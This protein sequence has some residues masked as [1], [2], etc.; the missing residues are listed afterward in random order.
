MAPVPHDDTPPPRTPAFAW[1]SHF[2]SE[3]KILLGIVGAISIFFLMLATGLYARYQ[4]SL[5]EN[6]DKFGTL[7][8]T[9]VAAE[10]ADRMQSPVSRELRIRTFVDT[11]L[12]SSNDL[13]AIEFQDASG[14]VLYENHKPLPTADLRSAR[15]YM[16]KIQDLNAS[17]PSAYLGSA[18][19]KLT[20]QSIHEISNY[21]RTILLVVF[22]CAWLL[23]LLAVSTNTYILHQ[24]L[25]RLVQGVKRLSTGDFGYKISESDLWGELRTLAESFNDMSLRLR[26]YEDQNLDVIT[27]ERNKLQ[28][29]LMSIADGIIVCNNDDEVMI[30]NNSACRHLSI[31]SAAMLT[32]RNIRDYVSVKGEHCL[33]PL[34]EEFMELLHAQQGRMSQPLAKQLTLPAITLNVMISPIQDADGA[35]LGFVIITHDITREAEVDRMKTNF[36]SNVSH[37][38]R[39][40]VTTIKSYIDTI[41]THGKDL[42]PDTYQ[43]FLETIHL[44]TDRLK[45]MVNDIL[46]FSRLEESG[47]RLE[48]EL[49]DITPIINLTVQSF[50]VLAQQKNLSITTA[51]ESNL[52]RVMINSDTI[53]R[54]MRN[55]LSNAVKYTEAGGRIRVRAEMTEK[56]DA[57]EIT[58]KDSGIGISPEHIPQIFDRFYRVENEVHTVKG[59]GLGLHLV[60]SAI[61]TYHGGEVFVESELGVGSTFGF[62]LLLTRNEI[63]AAPD[64]PRKQRSGA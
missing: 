32:G 20:G 59:T 64:R 35:E 17:G 14:R 19:I 10:G 58:V 1:L 29:V 15:V 48:L 57:V 60:K 33:T 21:T 2:S 23:T 5:N 42:D 27:F 62:R 25:S 6:Y 24:H 3:N 41:Y 16:A 38:L 61:E 4:T 36:I 52:P 22:G 49:Q 63:E 31:D 13:A 51:L 47:D 18:H 53:E 44:E 8:A 30:L 12:Q 54:V 56:G 11:I 34:V 9:V 37:E 40:P 26:A 7:L 50:K 39:T 28:A 45:K 43:E 55:L 46:D